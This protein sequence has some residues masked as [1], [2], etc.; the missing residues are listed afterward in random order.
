MF[1]DTLAKEL[2]FPR[3]RKSK[4]K[5]STQCFLQLWMTSTGKNCR[6]LQTV[7]DIWDVKNLLPAEK[8]KLNIAENLQPR[9]HNRLEDP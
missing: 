8:L 4:Q 1:Y 6:A 2:T 9:L 7:A 5:Q 3:A